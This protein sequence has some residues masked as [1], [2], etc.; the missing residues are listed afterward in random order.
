[1][2]MKIGVT[3]L[4]NCFALSIK[5]Y[6]HT[7]RPRNLTTRYM[8]HKNAYKIS[9]TVHNVHSSTIYSNKNLETTQIFAYRNPC[10]EGTGEN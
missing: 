2:G 7:L 3:A 10:G 4:E 1:M 5:Y 8:P 9:L 6:T